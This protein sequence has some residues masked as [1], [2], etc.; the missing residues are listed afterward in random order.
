ML[1][2]RPNRIVVNTDIS[3]GLE[4]KVSEFDE[5]F[6]TVKDSITSLM[7]TSIIIRNATPRDRYIKAQSS[8]KDRFLDC[9]DIDHVSHKFPKINSEGSEWLRTRLGRAIT[10]RRQYLKY[11]RDHHDK[12]SQEKEV[13]QKTKGADESSRSKGS[14]N[15][16]DP[17]SKTQHEGGTVRILPMS[18]FTPT[19]ASTLQPSK[20]EANEE[21]DVE[22]ESDSYS[23]TSYATS[24]HGSTTESK[25]RIPSLQDIT[26]GFPF[27]CPYC[28]TLQ[29]AMNEKTWRYEPSRDRAYTQFPDYHYA[30]SRS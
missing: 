16:L 11:C 1:G 4:F 23:Q 14:T 7:K 3:S 8:T 26:S 18:A 13:S 6:G 9:Y 27:E 17:T 29:D 5:I 12:F 20:L 30:N 28:W 22:E 21:G 24:V 19:I 15:T 25:R 2:T 10:Q